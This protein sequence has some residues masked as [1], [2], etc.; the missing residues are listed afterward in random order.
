[1]DPREFTPVWLMTPE[2]RASYMEI[3]AGLELLGGFCLTCL[4]VGLPCYHEEPFVMTR[5][6]SLVAL[7][8]GEP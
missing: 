7:P 4:D 1:M 6:L 2:E 3:R 5:V 8:A